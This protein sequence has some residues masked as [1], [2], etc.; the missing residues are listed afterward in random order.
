[1]V[2]AITGIATVGSFATLVVTVAP[3][4]LGGAESVLWGALWSMIFFI[5]IFVVFGI[6]IGAT[7]VLFLNNMCRYTNISK[8]YM[9]Y[10]L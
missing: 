8:F 9:A 10:I 6:S 2:L 3:Q 4:P 1:M 5:V 7:Y